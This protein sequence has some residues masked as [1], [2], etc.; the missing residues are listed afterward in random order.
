MNEIRE[1][2]RGPVTSAPAKADSPTLEAPADVDPLLWQLSSPSQRQALLQPGPPS[3]ERP[4]LSACTR[5]GQGLDALAARPSWLDAASAQVVARGSAGSSYDAARLH[6]VVQTFQQRFA[7]VASDASRFS[8]LMRT[9]FGDQYD[10]GKLEALRQQ[11]L[12]GDF[13]WMPKIQVA[14]AASLRDLTGTHGSIRGAYAAGE[15]TVYLRRDLLQNPALAEQVLGEELGHAID[16]RINTQD[17][18]GDE[19][20]LF[21]ELMHGQSVNTSELQALRTEDDHGVIRVDGRQEAVEF[22]D[23]GGGGGESSSSSSSSES[24]SSSG[25]SSSSAS[26]SSSE[27]GE[28]GAGT[29]SETSG[30]GPTSTESAGADTTNAEGGEDTQS[31][32]PA[33]PTEAGGSEPESPGFYGALVAAFQNAESPASP[34]GG[35]EGGDD[36]S[37]G[38]KD[39]GVQ[40]AANRLELSRPDTT[41]DSPSE[42]LQAIFNTVTRP[43][44]PGSNAHPG[45][46]STTGQGP[47]SPASNAASGTPAPAS[48]PMSA[49]PY[50]GGGSYAGYTTGSSENNTSAPDASPAAETEANAT[51]SASSDVPAALAGA[52]MVALSEEAALAA[53]AALAEGLAVIA[54]PVL[55]AAVVGGLAWAAYQALHPDSPQAGQSGP[56]GYGD[57]PTPLPD[58]TLPPTP[59]TPTPPPGPEVY[60]LPEFQLPILLPGGS[61]EPPVTHPPVTPSHEPHWIDSIYEARPSVDD[62]TWH[63]PVRDDLDNHLINVDS[64]RGSGGHNEASFIAWVKANGGEYEVKPTGTPGIHEIYAV[65]PK[66]GDPSEVREVRKT[67]YDPAVYTDREMNRMAREAGKLAWDRYVGGDLGDAK[68]PTLQTYYD[69]TVNGISFRAYVNPDAS[70]QPSI[71]N[72]HPIDPTAP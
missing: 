55:A 11:S 14:D 7:T 50:A 24:S 51:S 20:H 39:P 42:V 33:A 54:P 22:D 30:E 69:V 45:G 21:T 27:T 6:A 34:E 28:G 15:D 46:Q 2:P 53:A 40:L 3:R 41:D 9:A 65:I 71:G 63:Y 38:D 60:P 1:A 36:E 8:A 43:T 31:S 25:E 4:D 64:P 37:E 44:R 61:T 13:S 47:S 26:E 68:V 59:G 67:T 18:A 5:H 58:A 70:G 48:V 10:A 23:G 57:D 19:G 49:S 17:A 35:Q 29:T 62:P 56:P 32:V 66:P 72:I 16:A 12:A 52:A